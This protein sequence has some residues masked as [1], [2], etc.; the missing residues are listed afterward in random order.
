MN[1]GDLMGLSY[2]TSSTLP[3]TWNMTTNPAAQLT[4]AALQG[5]TDLAQAVRQGLPASK[6]EPAKGRRMTKLV[7]YTVVDPDPILAEHAPSHGILLTGT[8]MLNGTDERGFLMDLAPAVAEALELHNAKRAA[9]EYTDDEGRSRT[10]KPV[11]LGQ[12]D[13]VVEVVKTY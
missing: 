1:P 12:L 6:P 2:T 4:T 13:V 7:R 5:V 9:V 10:L 11:R 3:T 8:S